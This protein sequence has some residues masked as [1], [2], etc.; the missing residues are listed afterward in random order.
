MSNNSLLN[1]FSIFETPLVFQFFPFPDSYFFGS[2]STLCL[3]FKELKYFVAFS[4]LLP[5]WTK[6]RKVL[7]FACTCTRGFHLTVSSAMWEIFLLITWHRWR[8]W[9]RKGNC[10]I[11]YPSGL[12]FSQNCCKMLQC[13]YTSKYLDDSQYTLQLLLFIFLR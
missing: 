10:S 2:G 4:M 7:I 9:R 5:W 3:A 8:D 11:M 6:K 1:I 12:R 13:K